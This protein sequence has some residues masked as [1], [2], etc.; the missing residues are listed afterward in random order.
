MGLIILPTIHGIIIHPLCFMV[1]LR[2]NHPR[3]M[4]KSP[5]CQNFLETS[6]EGVQASGRPG[7]AD[8]QCQAGPRGGEAG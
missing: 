6:S 4:V 8:G 1:N 7:T 5:E 2:K 3:F